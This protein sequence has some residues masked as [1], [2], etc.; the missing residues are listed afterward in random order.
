MS[1]TDL[2]YAGAGV[3]PL[4]DAGKQVVETGSI[5]LMQTEHRWNLI[6]GPGTDFGDICTAPAPRPVLDVLCAKR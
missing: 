3:Q 5:V 1:R 4:D 6:I 2:L